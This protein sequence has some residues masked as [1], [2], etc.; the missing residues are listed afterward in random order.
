MHAPFNPRSLPV[1][2][3]AVALAA[4]LV[5]GQHP[6]QQAAAKD[7]SLFFKVSGKGL[8]KPS[9]LF[10]TVHMIPDSLYH[11]PPR[12]QQAFKASETLV[13]ELDMTKIDP[14]AMSK[15]A[16]QIM[17]PDG[18]SLRDYVSEEEYQ[19]VKNYAQEQIGI[20]EVV[21]QQFARMQPAFLQ[22]MLIDPTA[23]EAM[24]SYDMN[25]SKQ[26]QKSGKP[27][28]GLETFQE[29]LQVFS[30]IPIED[31][32]E[33]LLK[34]VEADQSFAESHQALYDAYLQQDMDQ[35]QQLMMESPL[36]QGNNAHSMLFQRNQNWVAPLDSLF[37][38]KG[39]FVAVGAAHLGG[40]K[41]IVLL[42]RQKGYQVKPLQVA[43]HKPEEN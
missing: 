23:R 22:Y 24:E 11:L 3:L 33:S 5:A 40:D 30:S 38:E 29:Q 8:E 37:Q 1:W 9:Y 6:P 10:G 41:G 25:F 31:Q 7:Q 35:M 32:V 20:Q 42:L 16:M 2:L 27:V 39:C 14:A 26:A 12:V 43:M 4:G 21:F 34:F 15:V 17:L 19:Q 18:K 28:Y 13:L 36:T